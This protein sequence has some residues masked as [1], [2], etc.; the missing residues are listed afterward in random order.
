MPI[1]WSMY[2]YVF[3]C[4]SPN[5]ERL[6]DGDTFILCKHASSSHSA[7]DGDE[8][9]SSN[10]QSSEFVTQFVKNWQISSRN[11]RTFWTFDV[12]RQI[13]RNPFTS[14]YPNRQFLFLGVVELRCWRGFLSWWRVS[15]ANHCCGNSGDPSAQ[16]SAHFWP[17]FIRPSSTA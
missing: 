7:A 11:G 12:A 15:G 3:S 1:S 13:A 2:L 6:D 10:S 14:S 5:S 4:S 8:G 9:I 17:Q 16:L